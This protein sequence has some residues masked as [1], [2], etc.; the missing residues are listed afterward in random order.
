MLA[1]YIFTLFG[2]LATVMAGIAYMGQDTTIQIT[3]HR[4]EATRQFF[5]QAAEIM[6]RSATMQN[7]QLTGDACT[8]LML[9]MNDPRSLLCRPEVLQ[10]ATWDMK[11]GVN[12]PWVNPVV[13]VVATQRM[14]VGPGVVAPVTAFALVSR[15][16]DRRLGPTL[17]SNLATLNAQ[18]VAG[19]ATVR[20]VMRLE[21]DPDS[22]DIVMTYTNLTAQMERWDRVET[23]LKRIADAAQGQYM[24]DFHNFAPQIKAYM[25]SRLAAGVDPIVLVT[26]P[27]EN[28]GWK[29]LSDP[30]KPSLF[31]PES[32]RYRLGVDEEIAIITN[33]IPTGSSLALA[34]TVYSASPTIFPNANDAMSLRLNNNGSP[35]GDF[36]GAINYHYEFI[37]N[38]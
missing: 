25:A 19:T 24:Q 21:A 3:Q 26:N 13:G 1:L 34:T 9:P 23:A 14:G 35:W 17:Q 20:N 30:A 12:D 5:N 7:L 28:K 38:Q 32:D 27:V 16:P 6:I 18:A 31:P 15:G 22:D 33:A 36:N 8:P 11:A 4:V 37:M 2:L 29:N 10:T